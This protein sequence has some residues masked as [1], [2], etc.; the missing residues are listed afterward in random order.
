MEKF[1]NQI[2][3]MDFPQVK[4]SLELK[5]FQIIV[6]KSWELHSMAKLLKKTVLKTKLNNYGKKKGTIMETTSHSKILKIQS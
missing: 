5:T 3:P 6:K 2:Q 1:G 4:K